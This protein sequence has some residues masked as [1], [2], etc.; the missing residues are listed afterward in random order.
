L[1][2]LRVPRLVA[3]FAAVGLVV[4]GGLAYATT[5]ASN[6]TVNGCYLQGTGT[7]RVLT[8]TAQTCKPTEAPIHW[9][10]K[11][12]P[13]AKGA[14]GP[15]GPAGPKGDTGALGPEGPRGL[16]T[17]LVFAHVLADANVDASRSSANIV[18]VSKLPVAGSVN[19]VVYCFDLDAFPRGVQATIADTLEH[20]SSGTVLNVIPVEA[21]VDARSRGGGA[22]PREERVPS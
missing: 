18:N 16:S 15:Q 7:L 3:A 21:T 11:G 17:P 9:S 19:I 13:G 12:P 2:G 22:A 6:G 8:G 4:A 5:R 10:V 14:T 1:R 20:P